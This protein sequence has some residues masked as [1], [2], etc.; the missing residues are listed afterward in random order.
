MKES[1]ITI[2]IQIFNISLIRVSK[3]KAPLKC[4][5]PGIYQKFDGRTLLKLYHNVKQ[6]VIYYTL[7]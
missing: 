6:G 1:D 3:G 7:L 2:R 5:E 4:W